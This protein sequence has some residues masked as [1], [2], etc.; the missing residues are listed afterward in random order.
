MTEP[1]ATE[2]AET[3]E[4]TEPTTTA[5]DPLETMA[6]VLSNWVVANDGAVQTVQE[7]DGETTI[8]GI[9]LP[10]Y[11]DTFSVTISKTQ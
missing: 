5:G 7:S 10:E 4:T 11:A 6:G 8:L 9:S 1:T 2:A 3:T